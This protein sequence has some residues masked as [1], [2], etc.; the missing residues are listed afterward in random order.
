MSSIIQAM[1]DPNLFGPWFKGDTWTAWR[2]FL[3]GLFGLDMNEEESQ[4]FRK[5]T[6]RSILPKNTAREAWLIVGRRGGKSLISSLV[7]VFLAF[8]GF[9]IRPF[10]VFFISLFAKLRGNREAE[11]EISKEQPESGTPVD[12]EESRQ[13]TSE[14]S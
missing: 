8:L 9:L 10:R 3:A 14:E 5:H 12:D 7:A 4:I 11:S 1:Q 13:N 2:A 6:A